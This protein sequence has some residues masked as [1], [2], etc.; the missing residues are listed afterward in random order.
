MRSVDNAVT[1]VMNHLHLNGNLDDFVTYD[2]L[3]PG[4]WIVRFISHPGRLVFS[5]LEVEVYVEDGEP[6][7]SV[8][9]RI[10]IGRR[11]MNRIMDALM[12]FLQDDVTDDQPSQL[13]PTVATPAGPGGQD[14]R[15]T[16]ASDTQD[17]APS[18]T[19]M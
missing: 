6:A 2:N 19:Y 11:T 13:L 10:H 16:Q 14:T 17:T 9:Q 1:D 8:L 12:D 5:L 15:A 7:V 18:Y 4:R 3:N